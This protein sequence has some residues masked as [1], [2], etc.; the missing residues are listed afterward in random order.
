VIR[1]LIADDDALIRVGLKTIF[2]GQTDVETVGDVADGAEVVEA[3]RRLDVDVV[4]MDIRMGRISGLEA[5]RLLAAGG[6]LSS[7]GVLILTTFDLDEYIDEALAIGASGFLLKSASPEELVAAV[8]AVAAGEAVLAPSVTRRVIDACVRRRIRLS[9]GPAELGTLTE[10][11]REVL[12]HLARGLSN[13]EI[14]AALSVG[15]NTIRTHV[16]H[17]LMKLNLRDRRQAIVLAH[18]NGLTDA[19]PG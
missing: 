2:A 18:E 10:R 6:G 9:R 7:V 4:L 13:R 3:V 17:L 5:T 1:L 11:E 19:G 16:A 14:A 15:E 12:R 8:R